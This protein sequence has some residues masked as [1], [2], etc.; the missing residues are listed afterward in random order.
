VYFAL[1]WT[2]LGL[3]ISDRACGGCFAIVACDPNVPPAP[4]PEPTPTEVRITGNERV[5]WDQ[6]AS[7]ATEVSSFQYAMYVDDTRTVLENP[8]CTETGNAVGFA[9]S[10]RLPPMSPGPHSLALAAF[11]VDGALLE[12]ARSVAIRVVVGS[13][14]VTASETRWQ[15]SALITTADRVRLRVDPVANG[16]ENPTDVAFAPDGRLLIAEAS[17]RVRVVTQGQLRPQPALVL[18]EIG[19][20]G[21]GKLLALAVDPRFSVTR[22]VYTVYAAPSRRG[23]V[24]FHLARFRMIGDTLAQR[25]V[26]LD[27]IPAVSSDPR[28]T[29]RFGPDGRLYVAFDDGGDT[30]RAGDL[31]SF[32]GKM[33]RLNPDGT[34]PTDQ[35][36]TPVYA[37]QIHSPRGLDWQPN[38][39]NLWLADSGASG[40][41]HLGI[42]VPA[43]DGRLPRGIVDVR[44]ALPRDAGASSLAFYRGSL[45]PG[46]RGDL[47]IAA[48]EGRHIL[49]LQFDGDMPA[50]VVA[51]E[52]LLDD[53]LGAVRCVAVSGQ[54]EIYF[55][56]ED[57]LGRLTPG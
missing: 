21:P 35:P 9:C 50:R 53:R 29:L 18:E 20:L 46:F 41:R 36:A 1:I 2:V 42:V 31:S 38:T 26:L 44:Y 43:A 27:G 32:N 45:I 14:T 51:T 33:F 17:G 7:S 12:S 49:R 5:G 23:V 3:M 10:A 19:A 8:S 22:F 37:N 30:R 52:R 6:Q 11:V 13:A 40:S 39:G 34:M 48:E 4:A 55:C 25:A 47:L 57:A 16:L 56:T 15:E 28:A 54:G 24:T